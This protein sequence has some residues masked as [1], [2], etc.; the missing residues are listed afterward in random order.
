MD[1]LTPTAAEMPPVQLV[2][3]QDAPSPDNPLGA[4]GAGEGGVTGC[5]AAVA[6]AVAAAL[7]DPACIRQLPLTP[8]RARALITDIKA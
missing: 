5:G 7:G 4:R 3:P 8:E 6:N 2:V 1:Y